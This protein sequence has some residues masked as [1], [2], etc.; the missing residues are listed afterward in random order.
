M[1]P[2]N[3]ERKQKAAVAAADGTGGRHR[4]C[5]CGYTRVAAT[6]RSQ[7][8][9]AS[10][11]PSGLP[12]RLACFRWILPARPP[13]RNATPSLTL[14]SRST[15]RSIPNGVCGK[16][17]QMAFDP[18]GQPVASLSVMKGRRPV[19][20]TDLAQRI[21]DQ[22][23]AGRSLRAVCRDAGTP[24]LN[25]VLKWMRD[26]HDGFCRALPRGLRHRQC[27]ARPPLPLHG[28]DRRTDCARSFARPLAAR[29]LQRSRHAVGQR[30]TAVGPGESRR[31]RHALPAG[32]RR[33]PISHGPQD[34]LVAGARRAD[35]ARIDPRPHPGRSVPR[36][37][38]AR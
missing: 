31:F 18:S 32:Q 24:D 38:N 34:P 37:R 14:R 33:Q 36:S 3:P 9:R 4:T 6:S 27:T 2:R 26:D 35:P 29:N 20:T 16:I 30:G 1:E 11:S 22:L 19:Y 13:N 7:Y 12:N 23:S 5:G 21:L 10:Q 28:R 8:G 17:S 15:G 25:T